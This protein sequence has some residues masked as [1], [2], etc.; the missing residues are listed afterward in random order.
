MYPHL[1]TVVVVEN[2]IWVLRWQHINGVASTWTSVLL[3]RP[4]V[5]PH[6]AEKA[7]KGRDADGV[8][9]VVGSNGSSSREEE[10]HTDEDDPCDGNEVDRFAPPAHGVWS[11]M[12]DNSAF[13]PAVCNDDSDVT[14][15]QGGRGDVENGRDG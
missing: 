2:L 4:S 1:R 12:E 8:V 3:P 6:C 10:N 5:P 11:G 13:I 14:N 9:H 7:N 15:V